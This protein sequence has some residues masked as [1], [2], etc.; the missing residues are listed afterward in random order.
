MQSETNAVIIIK[1][2]QVRREER[3][4]WNRIADDVIIARRGKRGTP[5]CP[6]LEVSLRR[7]LWLKKGMV[8][9]SFP[10]W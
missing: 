4:K 1:K 7:V 2:I 10:I 6:Y 5:F 8:I 3:D 9:P